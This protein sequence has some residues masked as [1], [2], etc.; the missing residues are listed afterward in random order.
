LI[1][2][3]VSRLFLYRVEHFDRI[4]LG[5]LWERVEEYRVARGFEGIQEASR[6]LMRLALD[7]EPSH[8]NSH[9]RKSINSVS[10][11]ESDRAQQSVPTSIV[12]SSENL[13]FIRYLALKICKE[14]SSD[15]ISH[16]A[17][18]VI[19]LQNLTLGKKGVQNSINRERCITCLTSTLLSEVPPH[20]LE[21][22]MV[23][24]YL[25]NLKILQIEGINGLFN[26]AINV[27]TSYLDEF[28]NKSGS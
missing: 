4:Y 28:N 21:M 10:L 14:T 8:A 16:I 26:D 25:D 12:L 17:N 1:K 18:R 15:Q 19:Y 27:F 9:M 20:F 2:P 23:I 3:S 13:D 22:M 7:G 24:I 11:T 6:E 5:R